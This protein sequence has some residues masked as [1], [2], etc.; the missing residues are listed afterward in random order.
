VVRNPGGLSS[1]AL[2]RDSP[3]VKK[4]RC[5]PGLWSSEGLTRAAGST[6][7][8]ASHMAVDKKPVSCSVDLSMRLLEC[9]T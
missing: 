1:V 2:A 8:M 9:L 6:S 4:S 5:C 7:K 3:E